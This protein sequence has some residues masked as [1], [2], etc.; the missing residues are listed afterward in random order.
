MSAHL[1]VRRPALK[2]VAGLGLLTML[3]AAEAAPTRTPEAAARGSV[4]T[5]LQ[6][7]PGG[8]TLTQKIKVSANTAARHAEAARLL[9]AG[10]HDAA[11]TVFD[12]VAE[13]NPEAVAAYINL[14]MAHAAGGRLE[15]AEENLRTALALNPRHPV[16]LNELGLVQRRKGEFAGARQ[17]Y[18]AALAAFP[19]FH[20][21]HRNLGVLCDLY[22]GE[23]TCALKHYEAY[24]RA[25]PGDEEVSRWIAD[26]QGRQFAGGQP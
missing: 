3:L 19:D 24:A 17:S 20:Y 11:V 10:R 1:K 4:R 22:L 8:F 2:L 15:Q 25:V 16:A 9:E 12:Q 23:V 21:A 13:Q 5:E 26:L 14:G 18:E 7:Q 6:Q